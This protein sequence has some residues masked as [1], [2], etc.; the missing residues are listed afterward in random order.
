MDYK[1]IQK[2]A[3]KIQTAAFAK[4][5]DKQLLSY[6]TLS[7]LQKEKYKGLQPIALTVYNN[8]IKRKTKLSL[9]QIKEIRSSYNPYVYGK[10]K[11]AIEYGVSVSLIY[12]IVNHKIWK[13]I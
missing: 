4:K 2:E 11:L 13:H 8:A 3:D 10:K 9:K 5:T 1:K 6:E 12:K 7:Q